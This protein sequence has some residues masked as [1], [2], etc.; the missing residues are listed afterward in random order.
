MM[1][2]RRRRRR[3]RKKRRRRTRRTTKRMVL[4][5]GVFRATTGVGS[6]AALPAAPYGPS[7][8]WLLGHGASLGK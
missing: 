6:S 2:R 3:R 4:T 1:M 7:A 5:P 8:A